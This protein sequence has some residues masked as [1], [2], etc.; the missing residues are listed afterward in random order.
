M[1]NKQA[2][3]KCI[4]HWKRMLKLTVEDIQNYEEAPVTDNCSLCEIHWTTH[5]CPSCPIKKSTGKD[6]CKNT[7]YEKANAL[8]REI[9]FTEHK[10]LSQFRKAVQREIKFLER[11]D[12]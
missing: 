3:R 6:Y 5:G 10:R 12:V 8:Y 1:T 9:F 7:P 2:K 11:L 4:Q